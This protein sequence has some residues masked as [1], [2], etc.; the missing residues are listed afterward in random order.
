MNSDYQSRNG[1]SEIP[2][3]KD[4]APVEDPFDPATADSDETL[5]MSCSFPCSPSP[6]NVLVWALKGWLLTLHIVRDDA[7]AIDESNIMG[8]R[9]RASKPS[10][11]YREP[12]MRRGCLVMMGCHPLRG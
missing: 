10:G 11:G 6:L 12:G 8:G 3:Q 9:T 7:D 5:G 1:Q 2:V 4:D